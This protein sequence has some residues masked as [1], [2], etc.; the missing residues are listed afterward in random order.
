MITLRPS[1]GSFGSSS[2][3]S[4]SSSDC[5]L[6]LGLVDLL[7][8]E[9]TLVARGLGEHLACGG[10]VLAG[11]HQVA[12]G[13]DDLAQL[14]VATGQVTQTVGIAEDGRVGQV[15][16]DPFVLRFERGDA[17]LERAHRECSGGNGDNGGRTRLPA[18]SWAGDGA[19]F[20][21]ARPLRSP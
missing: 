4:R 3:W 6:V 13:A 15:P 16:L 10:D 7:A 11:R 9:L 8:H 17:V 20:A 21:L 18:Q 14:L 5:T 19:G 2:S 1:L 12:P